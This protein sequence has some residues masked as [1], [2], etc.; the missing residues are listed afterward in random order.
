MAHGGPTTIMFSTHIIIFFTKHSYFKIKIMNQE[1]SGWSSE[2]KTSVQHSSGSIDDL[3]LSLVIFK[4]QGTF[5][6]KC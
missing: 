6:G 2:F 5:E 3:P 1:E 4:E